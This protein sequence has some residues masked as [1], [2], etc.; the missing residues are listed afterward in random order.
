MWEEDEVATD[1]VW[2]GGVCLTRQGLKRTVHEMQEAVYQKGLNERALDMAER[3]YHQALTALMEHRCDGREPGGPPS[4]GDVGSSPTGRK[5]GSS[6]SP[7]DIADFE[8]LIDRVCELYRRYKTS[9]MA[10]VGAEYRDAR[11]V[12]RT[13][14][15]M[16]M[17]ARGPMFLHE[18]LKENER[19]G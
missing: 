9:G 12:L 10:D 6:P 16:A 7:A 15:L 11:L 19:R 2:S 1:C 5:E 4:E 8:K 13:K 17:A 18:I 14:I 3:R